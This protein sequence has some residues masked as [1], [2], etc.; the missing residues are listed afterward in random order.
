MVEEV[1]TTI[2]TDLKDPAS[3][4]VEVILPIKIYKAVEWMKSKADTEEDKILLNDLILEIA[5]CQDSFRNNRTLSE[6]DPAVFA[7]AGYEESSIETRFN[8]QF[9]KFESILYFSIRS[10]GSTEEESQDNLR[11][12]MSELKNSQRT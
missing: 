10:L 9:F 4:K 7:N 11:K 5:M 2:R 12:Y 6:I 3:P 1:I 8:I